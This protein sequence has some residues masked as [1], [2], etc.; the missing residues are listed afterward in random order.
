MEN[1]IQILKSKSLMQEV[2]KALKLPIQVIA[3][4]RVIE[5]ELYG[6]GPL[7]LD[8]TELTEAGYYCKYEITETDGGPG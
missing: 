7:N 2:A 3:V 8:S 1:E 6:G 4:G 5:N